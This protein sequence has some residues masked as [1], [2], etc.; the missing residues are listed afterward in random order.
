MCPAAAQQDRADE[1]QQTGRL[2]SSIWR[3]W[4][5][6]FIHYFLFHLFRI[7]YTSFELSGCSGC[8]FGAGPEGDEHKV[9]VVCVGAPCTFAHSAL[10]NPI[11]RH[12][13][14]NYR[15]ASRDPWQI[16]YGTSNNHQ[17]GNPNRPGEI[18]SCRESSSRHIW[19]QFDFIASRA[20]KRCRSPD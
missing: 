5:Y 9:V 17:N 1:P 16:A 11:G 14:P 13:G 8:S 3:K 10:S 6:Y 18:S 4:A 19:E 15:L 2:R 20:D 7:V 12:L